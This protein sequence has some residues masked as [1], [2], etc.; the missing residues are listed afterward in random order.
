[1]NAI[2]NIHMC[3]FS[4][5]FSICVRSVNIVTST[6]GSHQTLNQI[7]SATVISCVVVAATVLMVFASLQDMKST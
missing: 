1:M 4:V 3:V 7:F 2:I 6:N 5:C